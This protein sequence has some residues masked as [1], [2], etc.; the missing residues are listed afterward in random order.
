MSAFNEAGV[1]Y[2]VVGGVAALA[3]GVQRITR[4]FD[5]LVEPSADNC[6]RA[7]SALVAL[8]AEEFLPRSKKWAAVSAEASPAWLLK[9]VRFF[10]SDA[11][12]IDICNAMDGIPDWETARRGSLEISAFGQLFRI[13]DKDTLI[14][15]KLAAGREKDYQDVT[16]INELDL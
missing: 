4:D 7:I 2:V 5:F 12:G 9:Q 15:S 8:R 13:L 11:G 6:R 1:D 14:A 3:H 16:E 10:D